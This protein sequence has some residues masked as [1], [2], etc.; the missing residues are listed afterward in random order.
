MKKLSTFVFTLFV[1]ASV[2]ACSSSPTAPSTPTTVTLAPGQTT[3]IGALAVK[4]VGVTIDTRCPGDALCIQA[5]DAYV[6]FETS[7]LGG[8]R[9][10]ELQLLNPTAKST[11]HGDYSIALEDLT[12]YP[13]ASM[14][15]P[16]SDY[17]AKVT[18]ARDIS[19]AGR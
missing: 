1:A 18:V 2:A 4:F 7:H 19:P 13:F 8:R 17:R 9:E 14:P 11:T 5:G 6:A 15:F 12:P 10:F 16:K 3:Q